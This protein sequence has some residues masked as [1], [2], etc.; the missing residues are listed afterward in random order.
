MDCAL[1]NLEYE[2]TLT[3]AVGAYNPQVAI[4]IAHIN[5]S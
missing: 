1:C 5:F 4:R 2:F 3:E